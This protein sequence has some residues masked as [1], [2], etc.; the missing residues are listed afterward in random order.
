MIE[1]ERKFLL[2]ELPPGLVPKHVVQGYVCIEGKRHLRVRI[3]NDE[4]ATLT[5]KAEKTDWLREEFEYT[6]PLED[7]RALMAGTQRR[8]TKTRY[9]TSFGPHHID[10]DV[11][12]DGIAVVEIEF[13][14]P[15]SNLPDYCGEEITGQPAYSN[16][17]LALAREKRFLEGKGD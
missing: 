15:I 1:Q 2:K 3:I 13:T 16:L 8:V 5:F 14:E 6:I 9:S 12:P 17:Q 4:K 7:A 10:I 11:Y